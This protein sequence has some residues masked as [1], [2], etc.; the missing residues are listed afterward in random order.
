[1][2]WDA[3]GPSE[4]VPTTPEGE[5]R[6]GAEEE[7]EFQKEGSF[8]MWYEREKKLEECRTPRGEPWELREK[9]RV[10]SHGLL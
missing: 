10:A 2:R 3:S 9:I 1:M 4:E 7:P 6:D 5:A 8:M